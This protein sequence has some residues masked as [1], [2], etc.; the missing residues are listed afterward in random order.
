MWK[1]A[2]VWGTDRSIVFDLT[3]MARRRKINSRADRRIYSESHLS[4]ARS[5]KTGKSP[6]RAIVYC[7]VSS[8]NQKDDLASQVKAMEAASA[9][10]RGEL[11]IVLRLIQRRFGKLPEEVTEK[12]LSLP[13][14][15]LET[16]ADELLDFSEAGDLLAWLEQN[17]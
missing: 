1:V 4:M 2:L 3:A 15:R 11:A 10:Q 9:E 13:L 8:S 6:N 16:L 12:I 17:N 7:R 14:E 5:L